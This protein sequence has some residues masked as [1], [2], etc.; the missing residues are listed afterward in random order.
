VAARD[1]AVDKDGVH[2]DGVDKDGARENA[3]VS[4]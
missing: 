1:A 2:K 4:A 3:E